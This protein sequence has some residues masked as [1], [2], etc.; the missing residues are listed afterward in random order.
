MACSEFKKLFL[1]HFSTKQYIV[2]SQTDELIV[3]VHFTAFIIEV[4]EYAFYTYMYINLLY[5]L[6]SFYNIG[7]KIHRVHT[8]GTFAVQFVQFL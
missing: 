6:Y 7:F 3:Q 5:S 1:S 2:L 8:G 4:L